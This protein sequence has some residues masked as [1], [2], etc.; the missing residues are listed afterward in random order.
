MT[1]KINSNKTLRDDGTTGNIAAFFTWRDLYEK[2]IDNNK[3]EWPT[4]QEYFKIFRSNNELSFGFDMFN[5]D[6][7]NE[8]NMKLGHINE[9]YW[10]LEQEPYKDF[11][12]DEQDYD[13]DFLYPDYNEVRICRGWNTDKNINNNNLSYVDRYVP[14]KYLQEKYKNNWNINNCQKI[15]TQYGT[16]IRL[17]L[18]TDKN[19]DVF[20]KYTFKDFNLKCS[21]PYYSYYKNMQLYNTLQTDSVK[22]TNDC[23]KHWTIKNYNYSMFTRKTE[24]KG[25]TSIQNAG[26]KNTN[27]MS[28]M[29]RLWIAL[30]GGKNLKDESGKEYL[31]Q[32]KFGRDKL[33][34]ILSPLQQLLWI[35][36][37][38]DNINGT[39]KGYIL[40]NYKS[41][42]LNPKTHL[43]QS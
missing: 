26:F 40:P 8:N 32:T 25:N 36:W 35:S 20:K 10:R 31:L 7:I 12:P 37:H 24:K 5:K 17:K 22:E 14:S 33:I 21:I 41:G 18:F 16:M 4:A 1:F 27:R 38:T 3:P 29:Q 39:W 2:D 19:G 11:Y 34:N 28:Q 43:H 30:S 6:N 13:N 23:F 9:L 15:K 42:V